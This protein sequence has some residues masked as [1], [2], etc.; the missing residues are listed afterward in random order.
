MS[1]QEWDLV[2]WQRASALLRQAERIQRNFI[3]IAVNSQYRASHGRSS[4]W[5]PPVN[6][7]ETDDGL[8]VIA[9]LPGVKTDGTEVRVHENH[10]TISGERPLPP[11]CADG[12]LKVWEI[13]LGRFERVVGPFATGY[14]LV[15]EKTTLQDG[16]L[17]IELR[18]KL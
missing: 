17:I 10:L 15:L 3:Q 8:W 5:E 6:I 18:K 7:V 12:E 9:A 14:S 13:P 11:C 4:S 1:S 16:L 2:I